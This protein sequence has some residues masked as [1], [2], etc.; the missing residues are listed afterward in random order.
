MRRRLAGLSVVAALLAGTTACGGGSD[1]SSDSDSDTT[2]GSGAIDGLTVSGD[3]GTVPTV[4]VDKLAVSEPESSVVID[5]DGSEVGAEDA[6]LFRYSLV[7]GK[8]GDKIQD[9]YKENQPQ[10]MV[11]AQQPPAI[12]D[13][14]TGETIGSRVA[15]AMPTSELTGEQGAPQMGLGPD[16]AL[17]MVIDL[18]E[19]AAPPLT[20]P[21]GTKVD[22]PADAPKAVEKDG[23]VT[24][25]DFADAPAD[26]PTKLQVIPLINGT[27]P[28]VK[29]GASVSVNYFGAVWGEGDKPF[30]ESYSKQPATFQLAKGALIDGWV[31]GL[32]GVKVGSRVML[33]IPPAQGYGDQGQPPDIPG[34]STLVFVIDVLGSEG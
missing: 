4:K 21:K 1:S 34:G 13:A 15:L 33:V 26:P 23:D 14:V 22:P 24:A 8:T 30:D 32:A 5:G 11:V 12:A 7:N 29:E 19:T 25:I 10:K 6:A 17:V 31:E 2:A 18:L 20:G 16:D 28:A 9:N 27:G 3:F